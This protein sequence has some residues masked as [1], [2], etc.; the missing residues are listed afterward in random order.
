MGLDLLTQPDLIEAA[1]KEFDERTGGKPYKSFNELDGPP[2]GRLDEVAQ[3]P[4][5]PQ[6]D[7]VVAACRG[8]GLAIGGESH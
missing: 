2:G 4:A 8:Q 3:D 1:K 7:G 5:H 6:L